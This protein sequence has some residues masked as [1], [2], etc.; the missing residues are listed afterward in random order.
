MRI[1]SFLPSATEIVCDLGLE[2]D[3]VGVTFEC[4]WPSGVKV[5]REIVVSTFVDSTLTP[6]EISS[7]VS[8]RFR[9]G[10]SLYKIEDA[11]LKKCDPDLIL[12]QDLCSVCA[13]PT[14]DID[15]AIAR[16]DCRAEI[17]QIDPHSLEDVIESIGAIARAAGVQERGD[18]LMSQLRHRLRKVREKVENLGAPSVFVLEW[19]DP[20]FSSGH[21]VPD[22]I[23]SAGGRPLLAN[24]GSDSVV[25][26]W[27]ALDADAVI[28]RPGPRLIDGV[29]AIAAAIHGITDLPSHVIQRVR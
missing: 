20:A 4:A 29:E 18:A 10:L 24:S 17:L 14:G 15:A 11:A 9:Q 16:L 5:G 6:G 7:F 27:D 1:V 28:V 22:L 21:W 19:T 23:S 3:L 13:V 8:E 26:T 2:K 25:V 12:S